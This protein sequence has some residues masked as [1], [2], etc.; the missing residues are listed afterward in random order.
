MISEEH[1]KK[2]ADAMKGKSHSEQTKKKISNT[3][4]TRW[5]RVPL[6]PN[7]I[8][9]LDACVDENNEL[10]KVMYNGKEIKM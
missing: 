8:I 5:I 1:R 9:M 2:I 7:G 6:D 4:K 3:L 10:R